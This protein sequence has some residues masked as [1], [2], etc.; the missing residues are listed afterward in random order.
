MIYKADA[1]ICCKSFVILTYEVSFMS[2]DAYGVK[3]VYKYVV[4]SQNPQ[5]LYEEQI[6][7]IYA[8]SFDD[9]Y[10]K[11]DK[12]V[13]S[14]I[15]KYTNINGDNVEIFLYKEVDCFKCYEDDSDIEEIYSGFLK[16]DD[17]SLK[18]ITTPCETEELKI[19][20]HK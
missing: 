7:K 10:Q 4:H 13:E 5:E 18:S 16:L 12:H 2:K 9:A 15:D 14:Y 1:L 6:L 19:L 20:R 17:N 11:A 3:L 8:E